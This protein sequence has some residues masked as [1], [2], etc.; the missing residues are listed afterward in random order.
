[1]EGFFRPERM[2]Q[3][4]GSFAIMKQE[5]LSQYLLCFIHIL[6]SHDLLLILFGG[7]S[8]EKG[9]HETAG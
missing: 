4:V 3:L 6:G 9:L 2:R 5:I 1:M 8:V 7:R